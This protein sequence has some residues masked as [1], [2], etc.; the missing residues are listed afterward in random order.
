M[1]TATT[2][3]LAARPSPRR[4]ASESSLDFIV[5]EDNG[6]SYHWEIVQGSGESLAQSVSFGSHEDAERAARHVHDRAGRARFEG[7]APDERQ[8]TAA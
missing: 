6:G 1:A 7:R 3:G 4:S 2:K 8:P 5:Y